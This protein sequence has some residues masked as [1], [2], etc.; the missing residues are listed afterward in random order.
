MFE[1]R[2]I[3]LLTFQKHAPL[4]RGDCF[5]L[6]LVIIEF[7]FRVKYTIVPN[8]YTNYTFGP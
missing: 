4:N 5:D 2:A 7:D 1:M 8:V 3:T 6:D